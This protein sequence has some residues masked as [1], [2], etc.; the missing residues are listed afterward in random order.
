MQV[1]P[2]ETSEQRGSFEALTDK[3]KRISGVEAACHD[4]GMWPRRWGRYNRL[5]TA[6][7][8]EGKAEALPL[9]RRAGSPP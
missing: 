8:S 3:A 1:L 7:A 5:G 9:L 4:G 2:H 6:A